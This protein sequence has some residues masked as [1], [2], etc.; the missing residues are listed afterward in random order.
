MDIC[1]QGGFLTVPTQKFLSVRLHSKSHKKVANEKAVSGTFHC[2]V[3]Q[4]SII[5][6]VE[7][8]LCKGHKHSWTGRFACTFDAHSKA[9]YE[10]MWKKPYQLTG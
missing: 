6:V 1:I 2:L 9:T 5:M 10:C 4:P 7:T 3:S 8:Y